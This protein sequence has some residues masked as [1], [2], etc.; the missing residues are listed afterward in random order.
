MKRFLSTLSIIISFTI[1]GACAPDSRDEGSKVKTT[2]EPQKPVVVN[3][4][5]YRIA[6]GA[7]RVQDMSVNFDPQIKSMSL[8][9]KIEFLSTKGGV[10]ESRNL[11]LSGILSADGFINLQNHRRD[12]PTNE[13]VRIA[14]KATCLSEEGTCHSSFID[15]Y[16]YAEGIVYH[17]QIESHQEVKEDEKT[18]DSGKDKEE[19]KDQKEETQTDDEDGLESEGGAD[20]VEGEPGQYIGSVKEDIESLLNV[21]PEAPKK[22]EPKK[23]EPKKEEPKKGEPKKE[24]PKTGTPKK[25]EPKRE[26]PKK[27]EPKREEPK[28]DEPKKDEPK[29]ETP[30]KPEIKK[31]SQAIGPV[32]N[33]RLEN[34]ANMLSY[35]QNHQPAGFHIIRPQRLTHFATNE[36]AYIISQMGKLTQQQIPGYQLSVGDISREAGGKLGSHKSHQNG[37]DAD[38]AF[39]FNNKSFQGYFAS[40]VAVDKPHANWMLEQQWKLFKNVVDTQLVDRIFIHKVLKKALCDLAIKNDELH[41]DRNDGLAQE[42]LRRL[43]PDADHHNHFHIRVK[44]SSAQVRCRQMA[45]PAQGS[46]CF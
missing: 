46:G 8:R 20:E 31:V 30:A 24:E 27:E 28:K 44:C 14:A 32:N 1:L 36:M 9:G 35:E 16:V 18:S 45:E 43:I 11:D 29:T 10:V 12:H 40:A 26:E 6:R 3:E 22:E 37:L 21:I 13:T 4:D 34:A 7:T 17:H 33:G 23:E 41:R 39:Y 5:G 19:K 42:T 25:D 15:I 2:Y 38:V